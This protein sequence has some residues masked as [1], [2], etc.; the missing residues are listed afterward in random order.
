MST[1]RPSRR[2]S[3][4]PRRAV[5]TG[6]PGSLNTGTSIWRPSV[7]SCSTAAGRCRSAPTINGCR[8]WLLNQRASL[9]EL[10]VLPEPCRPA[11]KMTVGGRE[12]YEI[13]RVSPPNMAVSSAFTILITCWLGS[14]ASLSRAPMACSRMR[15]TTLRTTPTLTSASSSAVRI[16]FS[17]SSTSASVRRPLP[18][19]RLTMPSRR[20]DRES[21]MRDG[22]LSPSITLEPSP[23]ISRW[24]A[25]R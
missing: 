13:L 2:A 20:D 17:I 21:N 16:S 23:A 7:R 15:A 3:S 10:V 18:R 4:R 5:D 12:A 14:S 1:S 24:T 22:T 19:S 6:S 8:P 9:A 11:I 25:P